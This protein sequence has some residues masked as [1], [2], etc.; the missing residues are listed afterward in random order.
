MPARVKEK[1]KNEAESKKAFTEFDLNRSICLNTQILSFVS[2]LRQ[3]LD[4]YI[5]ISSQGAYGRL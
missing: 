5:L 3:D 1:P 4:P 2:D